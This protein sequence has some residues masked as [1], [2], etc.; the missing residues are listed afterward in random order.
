[1]ST[2]IPAALRRR[3]VQR[4]DG[5]CEYC[6]IHQRDSYFAHHVD[7]IVSRKHGGRT[8][9][10]NLAFACLPCNLAKGSDVASILPPR[11]V[12]RLFHPLKDRWSEHFRLDGAEILPLS[13][14]GRVTACLLG[15]N[16]RGRVSE[17]RGF[18]REGKY[19]SSEAL[20]RL[21]EK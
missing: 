12:V 9:A 13:D 6:L 14:I 18:I 21:R 16:T 20:S 4:A 5:L 7:H 11:G 1:M 8:T 10:A 17:R 15:F 19:P 2:S 3:I